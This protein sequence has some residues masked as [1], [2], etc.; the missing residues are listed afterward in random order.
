MHK[1]VV[2]VLAMLW[3]GATLA[4]EVVDATG[5]SVVIPEHV[6]RIVPAGPPAA[7]L[8]EAIAPDLMVG[9]PSP[10]PEEARAMLSQDAAKLPQIARLT[11]RSDVAGEIR[12]LHPD[13]VVDYGTV[14]P[15]YAD[16]AQ[17]MQQRTGIPTILLDGSLEKIPG[18]L[19]TLGHILHRED[20]AAALARFFDALLTLPQTSALPTSPNSGAS[21]GSPAFGAHPRVLYARGADGLTVA[22]PNTDV[23]EVFSR[24]GWQVVAPDGQGTFRSASI[25]AIRALDPDVVIFSDPTMRETISRS[26]DWKTVRAVQQG[27]ALV[28]PSMPFGWVEEPPSI[29][30]LIGL[31]W[32]SG[33]DPVTLAVLSNAVVYGHTLTAAE[34]GTL[35]AGVHSVQ[36]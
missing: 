13:L 12:A 17:M 6:G 26:E 2:L 35:L 1:R 8:L 30:R 15:R 34:L 22:A 31:A 21:Q 33:R 16:L 7:V 23:T 10:L 25:D 4:A 9:W 27:H 3:S 19:R 28:A 20:R 5:R 24:L 29:N 11:S 36:Y 18:V 32:L 14:S